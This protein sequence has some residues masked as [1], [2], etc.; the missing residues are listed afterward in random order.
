MKKTYQRILCQGYPY[1]KGKVDLKQESLF[2][3]TPNDRISSIGRPIETSANRHDEFQP[4]VTY[5]GSIT[6]DD[7]LYMAFLLPEDAITGWNLFNPVQP[8]Y[9][10][11]AVIP[12][13]E[14]ICPNFQDQTIRIH[15]PIFQHYHE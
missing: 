6:L 7:E 4:F 9:K 2:G 13:Q 12:D 5:S 1:L 11:Y 3:L 15:K 10:L 8:L 14:L